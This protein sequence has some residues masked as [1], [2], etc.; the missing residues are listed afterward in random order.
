M[1]VEDVCVVCCYVQGI[2]ELVDNAK[3]ANATKLTIDYK[4][5]PGMYP[6]FSLVTPAG[7]AVLSRGVGVVVAVPAHVT[8]AS[9]AG[10]DC[11]ARRLHGRAG[12]RRGTARDGSAVFLG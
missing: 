6:P 12:S 9:R 2:A 1:C 7:S 4:Q 8:A 11:C 10:V 3:D 5:L